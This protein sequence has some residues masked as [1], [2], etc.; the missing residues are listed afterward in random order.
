MTNEELRDELGKKYL[1]SIAFDND[2]LTWDDVCESSREQYRA[3]GSEIAAKALE[4]AI[5]AQCW[6]CANGYAVVPDEVGSRAHSVERM[7]GC[8]EYTFVECASSEIH[9]LKNSLEPVPASS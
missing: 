1:A 6:F 4:E 8:G 2:P 9:A 7:E 5:K 3:K